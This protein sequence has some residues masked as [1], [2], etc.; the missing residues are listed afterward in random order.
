M[1]YA[2]NLW[3]HISILIFLGSERWLC[4][5]WN[6]QNS[7]CT[8]T[9]AFHPWWPVAECGISPAKCNMLFPNMSS[10]DIN[11]FLESNPIRYSNTVFCLFKTACENTPLSYQ[12]SSLHITETRSFFTWATARRFRSEWY[13]SSISDRRSEIRV[14]RW[15]K[16][17]LRKETRSERVRRLDFDTNL[18][19]NR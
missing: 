18:L 5:V 13:W 3:R 11:S 1:R 16:L 9:N 2:E 10:C 12:A 19:S 14:R 15:R 4:N 8:F 17:E 6:H 7:W